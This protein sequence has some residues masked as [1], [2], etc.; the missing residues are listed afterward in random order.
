MSE[1]QYHKYS[2]VSTIVCIVTCGMSLGV[3][4]I[5]G[6]SSLGPSNELLSNHGWPYVF[7]VR[8]RE[9]G[10]TSEHSLY[11]TITVL[12]T[13]REGDEWRPL[14]LVAN[15]IYLTVVMTASAYETIRLQIVYA[16]L[17]V[18]TVRDLFLWIACV[19]LVLSQT[20]ARGLSLPYV[21]FGV[22]YAVM[23]VATLL[24]LKCLYE[25]MT[26]GMK[27][28]YIKSVGLRK[29]NSRR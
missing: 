2:V 24:T 14:A 5:C 29:S 27:W 3:L 18:V 1:R 6:V 20:L 15:L 19:A 23:C 17:R 9:F 8:S 10:V 12:M 22:A 26:R 16:R 4:N 13:T 7:I 21:T 28:C 11:S 25:L